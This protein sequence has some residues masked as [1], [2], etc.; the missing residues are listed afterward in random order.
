[1][2]VVLASYPKSG[3]TWLRRFIAS[4]A[5]GRK[6]PLNEMGNIIP[7]DAAY[8]L[9][10]PVMQMG[11]GTSSDA[12]LAARSQYYAGVAEQMVGK[13]FFMKSHNA[14][15]KVDGLDLFN[16]AVIDRYVYI[17]QVPADCKRAF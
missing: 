1:M 12:Y 8:R 2:L 4:Y 9:W 5:S 10:L 3:N 17:C 15:G 7:S 13:S 14:F 16:D 6:V 11:D